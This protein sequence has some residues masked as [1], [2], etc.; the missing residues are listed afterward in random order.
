MRCD[1]RFLGL[2]R[3]GATRGAE[4]ICVN[5]NWPAAR[6]SHWLALLAARAIENQAYVAAVNRC[7][8]DPNVE[9]SGRSQIIDPRGEMLAD[10][11]SEERVIHA[12]LDLDDLRAY[13]RK[14][15]ALEDVRL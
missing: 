11:Q 15:P 9:Y 13:R 6:E 5:A 7:G 14:F 4:L 10:A 3:G 8:R 2:C 12:T 1:L